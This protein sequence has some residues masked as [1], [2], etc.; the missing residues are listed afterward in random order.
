MLSRGFKDHRIDI[1][2]HTDAR[3]GS[4][5]DYIPKIKWHSWNVVQRPSIPSFFPSVMHHRNRVYA[6]WESF[7]QSL[8]ILLY[9][10]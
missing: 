3:S 5:P 6:F 7:F 2:V 8:D 4:A 9:Y 1:Y 10:V